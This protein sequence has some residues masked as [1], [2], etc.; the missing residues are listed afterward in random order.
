MHCVSYIVLPSMK[1]SP[2]HG[3]KELVPVIKTHKEHYLRAWD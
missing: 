2:Q 1:K 3:L